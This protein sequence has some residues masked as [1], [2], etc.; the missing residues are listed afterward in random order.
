MLVKFKYLFKLNVVVWL[1]EILLVLFLVISFWY[2]VIGVELVVR[3]SIDVGFFNSCLVKMLVLY[4]VIWVVLLR[5]I[6]CILISFNYLNW[7]KWF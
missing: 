7:K 2:K 5:I 4:V 3:F 6:I 1:N